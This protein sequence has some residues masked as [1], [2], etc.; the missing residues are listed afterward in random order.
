MAHDEKGT[1]MGIKFS[2]AALLMSTAVL[3][4]G[5]ES[6]TVNGY[7]A[8]IPSTQSNSTSSSSSGDTTTPGSAPTEAPSNAPSPKSS[9]SSTPVPL[10]SNTQTISPA[11]SASP[12]AP[13][14]TTTTCSLSNGVGVTS[15]DSA[16][17]GSGQSC[18][19]TQCNP[20]YV[21]DDGVCVPSRTVTSFVCTSYDQLVLNTSSNELVTATG[22]IIPAQDPS[23]SGVCYYY[24]IYDG[25]ALSGSSDQTGTSA[26]NHDQDVLSRD[27]DDNTGSP[28]YVWHPYSMDHFNTN[29]T[30]AGPRQLNVTGGSV[31][32]ANFTTNDVTIDNFFLVGAYPRTTNLSPANL[33]SY[34]SA[35]G[36]GDSVVV[37]G[38]N[39]SLTGIPFNPA[40]LPITTDQIHTYSNGG[41]TPF[42]DDG[43]ITT[44]GYAVIPLTAEV[45][46]GTADVPEVSLTN[47][48]S[49]N[50]STTV[51]FR[52][53]DCGSVRT[54]NS[55]YLLV[56]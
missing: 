39:N 20:G 37:G 15:C 40:G 4:T 33:L 5:C 49:P 28:L 10:P 54:L 42:S 27:H 26:A 55:I 30:I 1:V 50:V 6:N 44:S 38:S 21:V 17:T 31:S 45:S 25:E 34:Y 9:P 22:G 53:L 46:G 3:A 2:Y 24:P 8:P 35:W 51:D 18:I 14:C 32:G 23:G 52:A 41:T 47:L 13:P 29:L 12:S 36:T 11:P 56:Q 7:F 19:L 48:I 43:I 16:Q